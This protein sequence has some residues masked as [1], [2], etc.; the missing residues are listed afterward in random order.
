MKFGNAAFEFKFRS[1]WQC[2]DFVVVNILPNFNFSSEF[3]RIKFDH[4]MNLLPK[5]S[6]EFATKEYWNKFFQKRGKSAFD[7]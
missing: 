7:W 6:E 5:T 1:T 4:T 2:F 3:G